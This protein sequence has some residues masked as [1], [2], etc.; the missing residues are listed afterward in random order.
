MPFDP[1]ANFFTSNKDSAIA[2][3]EALVS[4]F[5]YGR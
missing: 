5:E 4:I 2:N 1:A 3:F